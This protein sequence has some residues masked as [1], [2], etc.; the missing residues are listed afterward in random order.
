MRI[1]HNYYLNDK[2]TTVSLP[3]QSHNNN[4]LWQWLKT[5]VQSGVGIRS[6]VFRANRLFFVI[7]RSKDQF[8]LTVKKIKSP[9]SII[10]KDQRDWFDHVQ[11][12]SKIN[13]I[14]SITVNLFQRSTRAIRS[15]SLFFKDRKDRKIED[16]KIEF[17]TLS[18]VSPRWWASSI[19]RLWTPWTEVRLPAPASAPTP[20]QPP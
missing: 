20:W 14:D 1:K 3:W 2:K 15:R 11:S 5:T 17:P 8:D 16:R 18:T 7:K 6:S 19:S 12:F 10:F 9:P 4:P 13:E